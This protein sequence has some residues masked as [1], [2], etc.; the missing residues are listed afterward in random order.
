MQS[1]VN[2]M[3][4]HDVSNKGVQGVQGVLVYIKV[5]LVGII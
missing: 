2:L 5:V 4:S 1:H 3:M